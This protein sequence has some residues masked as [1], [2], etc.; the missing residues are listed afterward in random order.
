[1]QQLKLQPIPA[2]TLTYLD[3]SSN[4]WEIGVKLVELSLAF[5]FTLNGVLLIENVCAVSGFK[6]IPFEYLS[7]S[8]FVLVTQNQQIPDYQ[9]LG[10]SQ[11]LIALS[12]DEV[13]ALKASLY[14][15][16]DRPIT[17]ADFDPRGGLPLRFKPQ[18][19]VLA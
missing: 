3:T 8:N 10:I 1:M 19:Y 6:L 12:A 16:T 11:F 17:A 2:Q 14:N 7:T 18:G 4:Q 9:Q 15:I 5:S 13:E